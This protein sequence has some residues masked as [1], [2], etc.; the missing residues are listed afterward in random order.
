MEKQQINEL[1]IK[2]FKSFKEISLKLNKLNILIGANGSGKSNLISFF[3][4]LR[5]TVDKDD[6]FVEKNG[7]ANDMLYNG[8]KQTDRLSFLVDFSTLK[9]ATSLEPTV[10]NNFIKSWNI[11]F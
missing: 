11:L 6:T 5:A 4:F 10:N 9:I 7:S 8:R 1:R 2:G 3:K